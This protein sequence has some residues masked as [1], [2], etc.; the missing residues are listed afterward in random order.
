M[1]GMLWLLDITFASVSALLLLCI[2]AV[3]FRSWRDMRSKML[4]ATC[5]FVFAL[6]SANI[7]AA[8]FSYVLASNFGAAVAM[9][10][11]MTEIPQVVGYSIFFVI[12]LRY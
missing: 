6:M 11:M 12:S 7:V 4:L 8:Y 10:I 9:P 3:H 1:V 2:L 5:A